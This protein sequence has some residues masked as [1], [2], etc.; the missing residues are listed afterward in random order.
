MRKKMA[1]GLALL[2]ILLVVSAMYTPALATTYEVG[3]QVGNTADYTASITSSDDTKLQL[4]VF[5]VSG[6]V[7]IFN[8]SYYFANGTKDSSTSYSQTCDVNSASGSG[9]GWFLL[10]AKNLAA[11]DPAYP[12]ASFIINETTTMIVAGT[13]RTVN[14]L[15]LVNGLLN[16]YW[17]KPTGI[18]VKMNLFFIGWLNFTMTSMN[19]ESG[20]GLSTTTLLLVGGVAAVVI[21]IAAAVVVMRRR[22]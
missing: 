8:A 21:I 6:T 7:A 2:S 16:L 5:S 14:H 18:M 11:G 17:D 19:M 4:S 9:L 22:K 20:G 1:Y 13:N 12:T 10:I 15:S 3:V